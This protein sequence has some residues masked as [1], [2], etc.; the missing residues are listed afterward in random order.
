MHSQIKGCI[1]SVASLSFDFKQ[2]T[3]SHDVL[4]NIA[5]ILAAKI[6]LEIRK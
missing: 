6:T 5:V 1:L 2:R 4:V 3:L